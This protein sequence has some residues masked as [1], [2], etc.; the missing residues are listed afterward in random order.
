MTR[1]TKCLQEKPAT[2]EFFPA[3]AGKR[4]GLSSWCRECFSKESM[5]IRRK[6]PNTKHRQRLAFLKYTHKGIDPLDLEELIWMHPFCDA[7]GDALGTGNE[8]HIDHDHS[9]CP[10][11]TSCEKCRRGVLCR[12]CNIALGQVGESAHRLRSLA[13]YLDKFNQP[14]PKGPL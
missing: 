3:Y 5:K 1:C 4:N 6:N 7:C 10:K 11:A 8:V 12:K 14:S 2:L 13:D 9:C